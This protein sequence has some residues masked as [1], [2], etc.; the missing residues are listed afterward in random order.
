VV[1]LVSVS[2][3]GLFIL[4]VVLS[5]LYILNFRGSVQKETEDAIRE[6]LEHLNDTIDSQ[7][8]ARVLLLEAMSVRASEYM[9]VALDEGAE[10]VDQEGLH[11]YFDSIQALRDDVILIYCSNN[12]VW[13]EPGGYTVFSTDFR[14]ADD[15][16]NTSRSWYKDA[17]ANPRKVIL[18]D[19]YIDYV[20]N[21]LV[22]ATAKVVYDAN[23]RDVGVI[24]ENLALTTLADMVNTNTGIPGLQTWL[25][26]PSGVYITNTDEEKV[27]KTDFFKDQGFDAYRNSILG[28]DSFFENNGTN[29]I[30]STKVPTP[31]WA[32][33]SVMPSQMVFE[34]IN[35]ITRMSV[36]IAIGL[37]LI[38]A[39]I[40][41]LIVRRTMR[42]LNKFV[43][44]MKD[45]AEGEGDLTTRIPVLSQ[46]EIGALAE[47]FNQM[48]DKIRHLVVTI[49]GKTSM[50]FSIGNELDKDMTDTAVSIR[51]IVSDIERVKGL[52]QN[53]SASADRT[54]ATTESIT[55]SITALSG[56][57][58]KQVDSVAQSSSAIEEMLANIQ[59]V[60]LTLQHNE[61]NVKTL[62]S[63]SD[64]GHSGLQEVAQ[65]IE[66]ISKKSEGLLEINNVMSGIAAQTNLLS[67]NAAIEAAHAGE[68]GRGFAVVADE[69]RKLAENSSKQSKMIS[70]VLKSIKESIDT[71]STSTEGVL[72]Q[73]EAISNGV[74]T[75]A[76]QEESIRSSMAE[77]GEGS[78]QVLAAVSSM[79]GL[80][81]EVKAGSQKVLQGSAA[82]T[83]EGQN[84]K[85]SAGEIAEGM[86]GMADSAAQINTA[87]ERVEGISAQNKESIDTLVQ[88]VSKF[89]VD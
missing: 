23:G 31:G 1:K 58:D 53:Q 13:Y 51:K 72:E 6:N 7:L 37:I 39:C 34:D 35:R 71:I 59:Q 27:M 4:A 63:A 47:Y 55:G 60:T 22:V 69:I 11:D 2:L 33:V 12:Q 18:T 15:W 62:R 46:D 64:T 66:E 80:T 88:E 50:L 19:P 42:R 8:S 77:Q 84:L 65:N 24:S 44:T 75:V 70:T 49:K 32:L 82:I 16:D 21:T 26:H 76:V 61:A 67:M 30:F 25:V 89:K 73:F 3:A 9:A 29:I 45:I 56:T 54:N 86:S 36:L 41:A 38:L 20:T 78:K 48:M 83:T 68:A 40:N 87:V 10:N 43:V 14:P 81:Q 28:S 17:R 85:R 5:V 57:I 74:N 52:T 79:N